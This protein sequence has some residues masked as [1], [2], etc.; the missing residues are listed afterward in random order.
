MLNIG[1]INVQQSIGGSL[2]YG[3]I[4]RSGHHL[5]M[6]DLHKTTPENGATLLEVN[7]NNTTNSNNKQQNINLNTLYIVTLGV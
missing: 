5:I 6:T 3:T 7:T 4:A 1:R 2:R